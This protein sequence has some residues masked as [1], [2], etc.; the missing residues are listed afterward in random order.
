MI[1]PNVWEIYK[2]GVLIE[3]I[4]GNDEFDKYIE[5]LTK[6]YLKE[7]YSK[8]EES[9]NYILFVNFKTHTCDMIAFRMWFGLTDVH[10]NRIYSGDI[11]KTKDNK[12]CDFFDYDN[13]KHDYWLKVFDKYEVLPRIEFDNADICQEYG[14]YVKLGVFDMMH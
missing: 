5:K 11:L 1:L 4:K 10:G 13:I 14:I 3:E 6:K 7:G 2:N 12:D 8:K 9:R